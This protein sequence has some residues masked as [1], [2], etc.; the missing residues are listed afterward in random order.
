[1]KT[2]RP[3]TFLMVIFV[4]LLMSCSSVQYH[5]VNPISPIP[6]AGPGPNHPWYGVKTVESLQPTL[7]WKTVDFDAKYD[8]IVYTGVYV[9]V[10]QGGYLERGME[11]YYREGIEG[12]NHRIE[13][14][15]KPNTMYVWGIRTRNSS[16]VGPW[17]TYDYQRMGLVSGKNLWWSFRTPKQ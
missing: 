7:S 9:S 10:G 14:S 17:S 12:G 6:P 16:N 13:Q 1:M 11:I 15:L 3:L 2:L 5:G 8:L 4:L